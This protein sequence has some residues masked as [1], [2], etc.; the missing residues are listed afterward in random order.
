MFKHGDKTIKDHMKKVRELE[1][2]NPGRNWK[3]NLSQEQIDEMSS[4]MGETSTKKSTNPLVDWLIASG[5][6]K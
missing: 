5:Q 1:K 3:T 2:K 6:I 4:D